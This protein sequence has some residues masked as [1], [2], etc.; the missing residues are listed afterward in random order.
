MDTQELLKHIDRH[1]TIAENTEQYE[2]HGVAAAASEFLRV[3]A[4]EKT[5]FFR[6]MQSITKQQKG[7]SYWRAQILPILRQYRDYVAAGLH[8]AVSPERQAKMDVVSDFLGQADTLLS[9]KGVHPACATVLIGASLE[10]FLREWVETENLKPT[11]S[12]LDGYAQALLAKEKINKQDVKDITAWAGRRND[13]A[14]GEW[15][16]VADAQHVRLMLDGVNLF[17]RKYGAK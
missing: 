16:K 13:A 12:G 11:K 8:E 5:E 7:M 9:T 14:H 10:A 15:D 3:Y 17:M 4:G 2:L 6:S 1:I